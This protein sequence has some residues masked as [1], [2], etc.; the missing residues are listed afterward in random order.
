GRSMSATCDEPVR[1]GPWRRGHPFA[2]IGENFATTAARPLFRTTSPCGRDPSERLMKV[3][4]EATGGERT[5][6]SW[7][8]ATPMRWSIRSQILV[9]IIA[10]Q[11]VAVTAIVIVPATLAAGRSERQI[12]ARLN[13]VIDTL[14]HAN[15]PYTASV[16]AQ[17]RGLSGAHFIAYTEDGRV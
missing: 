4:P 10:I 1:A 2:S 7:A 6:L 13:G 15:F 11:A 9:P 12:V 17:M 14:G 16:L 8:E 5:P 3:M